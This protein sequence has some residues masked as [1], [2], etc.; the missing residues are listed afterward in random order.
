MFLVGVPRPG[1]V[2]FASMG[3]RGP[4]R[5][6]DAEMF[7]KCFME[8]RL[9]VLNGGNDLFSHKWAEVPGQVPGTCILGTIFRARRAP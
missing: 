8:H 4:C 7:P 5:G 9:T 1:W 3:T 2:A 6:S